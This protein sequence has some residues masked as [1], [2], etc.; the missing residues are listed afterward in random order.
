MA[1]AAMRDDL[2]AV[3]VELAASV[4]SQTEPTE[5]TEPDARVDAWIA[6]LGVTAT[7]ALDEAS[8]AVH[9]G[10]DTGLATLSVALRR[11]R[12]LVR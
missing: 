3:M 12:S 4:I 8:D 6:G 11:L 5:P 10:E 7:R 9:A 1:R 2:Y